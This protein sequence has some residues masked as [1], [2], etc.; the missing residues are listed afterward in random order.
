MMMKI[1]PTPRGKLLLIGSEDVE[2][3]PQHCMDGHKCV[4]CY[5]NGKYLCAPRFWSYPALGDC[6][7]YPASRKGDLWRERGTEVSLSAVDTFSRRLAG[8]P[9]TPMPDGGFVAEATDQ[10]MN[11]PIFDKEEPSR[12]TDISCHWCGYG[13]LTFRRKGLPHENYR[14]TY[15]CP[16][17]GKGNKEKVRG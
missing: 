6:P 7:N 11:C 3:Y 1:S 14:V 8:Q 9:L 10:V 12:V 15:R 5:F 2:V 16:Q 17:C 13:Y 4:Q